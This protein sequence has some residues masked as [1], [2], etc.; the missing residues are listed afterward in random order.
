LS[1]FFVS[2]SSGEDEDNFEHRNDRVGLVLSAKQM[3]RNQYPVAGALSHYVCTKD[4]YTPV[5]E[6]SPMFAID[7]EMC[8]TQDRKHQLARI[9]IVD[10]Q[11]NV[12]LDCFIV[13]EEPVYDYLTVYSGVTKED[14]DNATVTLE[15]LQSYIR[16]ELPSNAILVGHSLNS[17]LN[18]MQMCHPYVIDTSVV[19]NVSGY[20]NTKPSL[21][22]LAKLHLDQQIQNSTDGHCS[23]ED[24]ISTMSL[25]KLK[26]QKGRLYGDRCMVKT[27]QI[28]VPFRSVISMGEYLQDR[29]GAATSVYFDHPEC[30]RLNKFVSV[31]SKYSLQL[32]SVIGTALASRNSIC[33]VAT[34]NRVYI[35]ANS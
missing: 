15:E 10:E 24:A 13:P 17:D 23:V 32:N 22:S 29:L 5:S 30:H 1:F 9:S 6:D 14:L 33:V 18:A 3:L 8:Y 2:A 20:R 28:N 26:L 16:D 4:E 25:V 34:K 11:L 12:L 35:N 31:H 19:F 7:C 21:K 27:R